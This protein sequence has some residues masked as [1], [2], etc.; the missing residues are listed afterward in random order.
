MRVVQD[1]PMCNRQLRSLQALHARPTGHSVSH[2]SITSGVNTESEDHPVQ[3]TQAPRTP[4]SPTQLSPAQSHSAAPTPEIPVL[5][6]TAC[7]SAEA[8]RTH[9]ERSALCHRL[10]VQAKSYRRP[11]GARIARAHKL[12][13]VESSDGSSASAAGSLLVCTCLREMAMR[14]GDA[15]SLRLCCGWAGQGRSRRE[16]YDFPEF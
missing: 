12:C 8:D 1:I 4:N 11:F 2:K 7:I 5:A 16:D 9:R 6:S 13:A 3:P 14:I 10:S 15:L